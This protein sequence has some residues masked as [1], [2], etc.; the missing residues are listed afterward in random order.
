MFTYN[1]ADKN[2]MQMVFSHDD[3]IS[4]CLWSQLGS[5]QRSSF[6]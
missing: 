3:N 2:K 6:I 1:M 4:S 5:L